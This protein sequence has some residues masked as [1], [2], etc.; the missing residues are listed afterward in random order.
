MKHAQSELP[1]MLFSMAMAHPSCQEVQTPLECTQTDTRTTTDL[2]P[3]AI[4]DCVQVMMFTIHYHRP[5]NG[6]CI[7][8]CFANS[9][10]PGYNYNDHDNYITKSR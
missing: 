9:F 3:S 5:H 8:D 7:N 2:L 6:T 1:L 4:R 10:L